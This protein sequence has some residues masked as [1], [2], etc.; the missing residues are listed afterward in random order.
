MLGEVVYAFPRG[1]ECES[2]PNSNSQWYYMHSFLPTYELKW[3]SI[4]RILLKLSDSC[5]AIP[6][7]ARFQEYFHT[8]GSV[9]TRENEQNINLSRWADAGTNTAQTQVGVPVIG[10][11]GGPVSGAQEEGRVPERAA[12]DHPCITHCRTHRIC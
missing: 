9:G 1:R 11:V 3:K 5:S 8:L 7:I 4:I 12:A 10:Q 2:I 6:S